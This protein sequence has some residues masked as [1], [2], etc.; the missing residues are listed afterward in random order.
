MHLRLKLCTIMLYFSW[1]RITSP[2]Q[3]LSCSWGLPHEVGKPITAV[4]IK[5]LINE[6]L[7][8]KTVILSLL[9]RH[10]VQ[11]GKQ[12]SWLLGALRDFLC[13][14][15]HRNWILACGWQADSCRGHRSPG[16]TET[17]VQL[18]SMQVLSS[19]LHATEGI[20][21]IPRDLPV[22]CWGL[23]G[24]PPL[25]PLPGPLSSGAK[26]KVRRAWWS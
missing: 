25:P 24:Q 16:E 5:K 2:A 19:S 21:C 1:C 3:E 18:C 15:F 23:K 13:A 17:S 8:Y 12:R 9:H 14:A 6:S 11:Q 20:K 26:G 22:G 7:S 10:V 4:A